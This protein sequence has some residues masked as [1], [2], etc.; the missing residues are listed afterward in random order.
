MQLSWGRRAL[1]GG[2]GQRETE[3][4]T[5]S[6][7]LITEEKACS[8]ALR[9]ASPGCV[10][11]T[12]QCHIDTSVVGYRQLLFLQHPGQLARRGTASR[13]IDMSYKLTTSL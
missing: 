4:C 2:P 1:L 11:G 8:A 9:S 10:H 7:R 5:W 12:G 3:S 13:H 6:S